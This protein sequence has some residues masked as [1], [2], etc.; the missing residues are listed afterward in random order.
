[1]SW[2]ATIMAQR[3]EFVRLA[4]VEGQEFKEACSR[5]GISR[6]TGYKWM[7]RFSIEGEAGL[8]DQSRRPRTSPEKS[9]SKVESMVLK[10]RAKNPRWGGRKLQ[11]R[12][13][14]LGRTDVPSASTITSIL[15]RHGL[16]SELDGAGQ[17]RESQRFER[18]APN[19]LW[20]MDFKGHFAMVG[21]G[22]CHP[23]TVMDDHSRYS[24]GIRSC[25]NETAST[26]MRELEGM[27]RRYGLPVQMLMDNGSPW[28]YEGGQPWT[29][30]TSWL[31][32]LGIR[33]SHI[34]P[35]R[36]QTQGKAERFHRTLKAEVLRDQSH[37]DLSACQRDFDR[38]RE[39]YN[40]ERPH[41]SLDMKVPAS[42]YRLSERSYP[43]ILPVIEY[44]SDVE[45]RRVRT[46]N[47][48]TFKKYRIRIGKP[49]KGQPVGL[50]ASGT[51]GLYEV[52]YCQQRIGWIDLRHAAENTDR[53]LCM[54]RRL[55]D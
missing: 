15:R 54:I 14:A 6:K 36:P 51:E 50:R 38:W 22:R 34:R 32:R 42:R 16:L 39:V 53:N 45:V 55:D 33:I 23:L 18:E 10:L 17:P 48:I 29:I 13:L 12:L 35:H 49:F 4:S 1:M 25:G 21:G 47:L 41:E 20:Q 46:D 52:Y 8:A 37:L 5:F 28:G 26:V 9:S 7:K 27:F 43:E 44:G 3:V 2:K 31:V 24:I 40:R 30:V 11:A 19:D